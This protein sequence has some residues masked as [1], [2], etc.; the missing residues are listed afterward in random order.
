MAVLIKIFIDDS[1]KNENYL[2][3]PYEVLEF[4][5]NIRKTS[6]RIKKLESYKI[7]NDHIVSSLKM[8]EKIIRYK[9][10]VF[11]DEFYPLKYATEDKAQ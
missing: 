4:V 11:N 1:I 6:S 8:Y 7:F 5:K 2:C 9:S 3:E 10:H